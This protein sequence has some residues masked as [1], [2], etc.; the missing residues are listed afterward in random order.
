[1]RNKFIANE[2]Q[3]ALTEAR[4]VR[5]KLKKPPVYFLGGKGGEHR[6]YVGNFGAMIVN[7]AIDNFDDAMFLLEARRHP[8]ACV[9]ARG[10]IETI[11]FGYYTLHTVRKELEVSGSEAA[12]MLVIKH[13]NSNFFK[14]KDQAALKKG[15]FDLDS[16]EFTDEA[17]TRML[18]ESASTVRVSKA[19]TYMFKDEQIQTGEKESKIELVYDGLCEWTHPSQMSLFT[20]YANGGEMTPTS[21][22]AVHVKQS[23]KLQCAMGL[24]A[25]VFLPTL[26]DG[27]AA[28]SSEINAARAA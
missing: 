4:S 15:V 18:S 26:I 25:I 3:S 16:H 24:K 17:K 6:D 5:R 22:G 14:T 20:Y 11:A 9:I 8:S 13:T 12:D 19:L 10:L 2:T 28:L 23:A 21:A 1:M 7:R 27:Y